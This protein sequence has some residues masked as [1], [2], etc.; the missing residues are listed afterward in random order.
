MDKRSF[1]RYVP[2]TE[3]LMSKNK[4][5]F[6]KALI[7]GG[8]RGLG[9]QLAEKAF[10]RGI[11]PLI[12]GRSSKQA[13]P[14][15]GTSTIVGRRQAL[16]R[17]VTRVGAD[18]STFAGAMDLMTRGLGKQVGTVTHFLYTAG[19]LNTGWLNP[20]RFPW[21]EEQDIRA[22]VETGVSG[23]LYALRAFLQVRASD[24]P[25]RITLIAAPTH[26]ATLEGHAVYMAVKAAQVQFLR[27]VFRHLPAGSAVLIV[28][29][30]PMQTDFWRGVFDQETVAGFLDPALV[31]NLVWDELAFQA[32]GKVP[33][34]Q[35]LHIHQVPEGGKPYR[36]LRGRDTGH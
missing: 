33:S 15:E 12:V 36:L 27:S 4:L 2:D 16:Q 32:E 5:V 34:F 10:E 8:T 30:D 1:F 24:Q 14:A 22:Q 20:G 17:S 6:G 18:L 3:G 7:I 26:D 35:K 28:H 29:P 31:A 23:L 13:L 21:A 19:E 11:D 25:I 9:R